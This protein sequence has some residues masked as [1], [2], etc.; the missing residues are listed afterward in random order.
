MALNDSWGDRERLK[1]IERADGQTAVAVDIE[2]TDK[3]NSS[4][5]G[6][7]TVYA[8]PHDFTAVFA[9]ATTITLTGMPY[10]PVDEDFIKVVR[11]PTGGGQHT[12]YKAANYA[13]DYVSGTGVLTVTGAAFVTGDTYRIEVYGPDKKYTQSTDSQRGEEIDPIGE[14]YLEEELVDD[15]DLGAATNYYPSS[16]GAAMSDSNNFSIHAVTSGGVTTTVEGKIDDSTDWV[17]I[18][19]AGYRLDDNTTGNAS[20]VDQTFILDF[21]N[22]HVRNVRIKSITADATN[23]VQ[24][25]IKRTSI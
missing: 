24:Y 19:P 21:D 18:T 6:G 23:A 7:D 14:H 1:F 8:S 9:S 11:V 5:G 20:F 16:T 15:T 2:A 3:G 10:T 13:F 4:A 22:L 25:H 12:E 17:D